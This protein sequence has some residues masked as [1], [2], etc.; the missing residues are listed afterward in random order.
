MTVNGSLEFVPPF[1]Y[2]AMCEWSL[3]EYTFIQQTVYSIQYTFIQPAKCE[4]QYTF[5]QYALYI[6][7]TPVIAWAARWNLGIA[8]KPFTEDKYNRDKV[9]IQYSVNTVSIQCNTMQYLH[10]NR[11]R[12]DPVYKRH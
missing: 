9:T 12:V 7:T 4:Y 10:Y 5:I 2:S 6:Y 1:I 11:D 3:V 8:P